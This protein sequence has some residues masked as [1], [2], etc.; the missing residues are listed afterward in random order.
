MVAILRRLQS[1]GIDVPIPWNNDTKTWDFAKKISEKDVTFFRYFVK[2]HPLLEIEYSI[3][4]TKIAHDLLTKNAAEIT[5]QLETALMMAE[6]LEHIYHYYLNVPSAVFRMRREQEVYQGL[7]TEQGYHFFTK[8]LHSSVDSSIS[9]DIRVQTGDA[10]LFRNLIARLRRLLVLSTP[11]VNDFQRYC[12][13]VATIDQVS[14]PILSYASWLFFIP[15]LA[16]N[17]F[18]LGKH[19]FRGEWMSN[20]EKSL[21]WTTRFCAQMEQRWFELGNDLAWITLALLNCFVLTGVLAPIGF[22]GTAILLAYDVML[23]ALRFYIEISRLQQ[24]EEE[25]NNILQSSDSPD[26]ADYLHHLQDRIAYEKKRLSVQIINTSLL[27]LAF[28]LTFPLFAFNPVIPMVGAML[29]VLVTIA[30][31]IASQMIAAEKPV[32]TITH[33]QKKPPSITAI[34]FFKPEK[35]ETDLPTKSGCSLCC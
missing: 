3:F 20:E 25:Y 24:L 7:L 22:Y 34:S 8:E 19:V 4:C 12:S 21:E 9:R 33:V 15:R 27:L 5:Q 35:K 29:A 1:H 23:A 32:D 30:G 18:L 13:F 26:D 6:L 11:I 14:G 31:Y 28:S 16:T 17:L 10:N 2:N